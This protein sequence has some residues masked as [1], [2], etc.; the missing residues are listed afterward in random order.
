MIH[1]LTLKT[2]SILVMNCANVCRFLAGLKCRYPQIVLREPEPIWPEQK[3]ST[4]Y[5][6]N[7]FT[8]V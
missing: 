6:S 5:T 1:D 2:P 4:G 7:Y 8:F 3:D